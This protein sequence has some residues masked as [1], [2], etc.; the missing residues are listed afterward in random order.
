MFSNVSAKLHL[1]ANSLNVS[2]NCFLS[3]GE[4]IIEYKSED[5]NFCLDPNHQEFFLVDDG[6]LNQFGTEVR[7][8]SRLQQFLVNKRM[9]RL[10]YLP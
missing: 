3:Q 2:L 10:H 4:E 8:R 7:L 5:G 6:T 1:Y 9:Y